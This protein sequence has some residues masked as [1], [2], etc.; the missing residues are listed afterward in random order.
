[1]DTVYEKVK[2]NGDINLPKKALDNL[3][4]KAGERIM[5]TIEKRRI[6]IKPAT[7]LSELRGVLKG[8]IKKP[9]REIMKELRDEDRE[10]DY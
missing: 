4:I 2:P 9:S 3:G 8:A 10:F 7:T 5:L 1:M 6:G